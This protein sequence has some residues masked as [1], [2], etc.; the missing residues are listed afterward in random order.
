MSLPE[1]QL[2][3]RSEPSLDRRQ[4]V[5]GLA[6]QVGSVTLAGQQLLPVTA[7]LSALLPEAGLRRGSTLCIGASG[8]TAGVLT[9]AASLVS[10]TVAAGSWCAIVDV[11]EFGVAAAQ[12]CGLDLDRCIFVP[13]VETDAAVWASVVAAFLDACDVV[14]T[15]APRRAQASLARRLTARAR[16]RKSVLVVLDNWSEPADVQLSVER[17]TWCGLGDG[18]GHLQGRQLTVGVGGRGSAAQQRT[19]VVQ[20]DGA[21]LHVVTP[22]ADTPVSHVVA[23]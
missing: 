4:T 5:A 20:Q 21:I 15:R 1:R 13:S 22:A 23:G 10:E 17:V 6:Q 14:I 7:S 11:P 9:I 2:P 12:S 3:E 18:W 8:S 19:V 16:E